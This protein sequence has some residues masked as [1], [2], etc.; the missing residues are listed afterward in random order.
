MIHIDGSYMEGG[1]QIV[2]TA[3]ALSTLTRKP[4]RIEFFPGAIKAADLAIDIGTA[5]SVRLPQR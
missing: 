3:L 1:G 5:G 2:R 4:F